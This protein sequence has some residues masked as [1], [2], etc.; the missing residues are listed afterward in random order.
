MRMNVNRNLTSLLIALASVCAFAADGP[1]KD[2]RDNGAVV[3]PSNRVSLEIDGVTVTNAY[4][5]E[6]PLASVDWV[7]DS[8]GTNLQASVKIIFL[9]PFATNEFS[10]WWKS[11]VDGN[12]D[13]RSTSIIYSDS[14]GIEFFRT[15]AYNCLVAKWYFIGGNPDAL[16][17][18]V[19]LL[20]GTIEL[21]GSPQIP[22]ART[23]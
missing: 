14:N 4:E 11:A 7:T 1:G 2:H 22:L 15:N 10:K 23:P 8:T 21:K 3:H 20:C 13:R 5:I 12:V 9:H 17:E 16:T 18:K 6:G 19:E